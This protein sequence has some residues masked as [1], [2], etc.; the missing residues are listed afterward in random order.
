M[1]EP[2][3]KDLNFELRTSGS[4]FELFNGEIVRPQVDQINKQMG[5]LS[6]LDTPGFGS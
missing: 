5:P 3:A 4:D 6:E 2:K 1:S